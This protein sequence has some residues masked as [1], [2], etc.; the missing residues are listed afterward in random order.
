MKL[1]FKKFGWLTQIPSEDGISFQFKINKKHPYFYWLF[2]SE[3]F[4]EMKNDDI[5][6]YQKPFV[7][8]YYPIKYWI[9]FIKDGD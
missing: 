6:W 8:I 1:T 5:K 9:E 3:A 7:L 2:L 4:K